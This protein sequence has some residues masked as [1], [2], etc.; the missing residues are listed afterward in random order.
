MR[1]S[2]IIERRGF[3]GEKLARPDYY[4]GPVP[5]GTHGTSWTPVRDDALRFARAHDAETFA[6]HGFW[7]NVRVVPH[8]DA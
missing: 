3:K 6:A 8:A 5:A 2:F 7:V 4:A 1:D